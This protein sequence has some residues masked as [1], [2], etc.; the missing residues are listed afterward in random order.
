MIGAKS[1]GYNLN[2][3]S[4]LEIWGGPIFS[5]HRRQLIKGDRDPSPCDVCNVQ[6]TRTGLRSRE[7][8]AKVFSD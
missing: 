4:F 2:E 1:R 7:R 5:E 3:S 8:V 6:G